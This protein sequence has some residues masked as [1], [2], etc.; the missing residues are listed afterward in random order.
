MIALKVDC[1]V[2]IWSKRLG[3]V[4]L[5][6]FLSSSYHGTLTASRAVKAVPVLQAEAGCEHWRADKSA[7]VAKKAITAANDISAPVPSENAIPKDCPH[8]P[9]SKQ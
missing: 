4:L 3:L 1:W 2:T 6:W 9:T 5:G 7:D 8:Q